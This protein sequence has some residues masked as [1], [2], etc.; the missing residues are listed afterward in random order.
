LQD[1]LIIKWYRTCFCSN[2]S[3]PL[4]LTEHVDASQ[5]PYRAA[6]DGLGLTRRVGRGRDSNHVTFRGWFAP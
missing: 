3:F 2:T 1:H 5:L 4:F 6:P